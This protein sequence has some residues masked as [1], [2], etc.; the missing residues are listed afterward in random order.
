[1]RKRWLSV[2]IVLLALMF[3]CYAFAEK[4]GG[5]AKGKKRGA[6]SNILYVCNCGPECKCNTVSTKPGKCS[7]G[8]ALV[9]M[10]ILKIEKDEAL[11]CTCGK[12]CSCKLDP[13]DPSKCG[14]G[15]DVKRVSI[16]GLYACACGE[17]CTCNRV[18]D[19]PGKCRC[20]NE[21][22]KVE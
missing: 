17:G 9:P 5:K 6:S 22:K 2:F 1:M 4:A 14:C 19:K 12:G 16:K 7:C 10:H 3:S 21:L 15:K 13:N 8:E 20:G 18:S 11:L